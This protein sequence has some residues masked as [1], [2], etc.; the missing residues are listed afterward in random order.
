MLNRFAISLVFL[1]SSATFAAAESV[2][3]TILS[4]DPEQHTL[5]MESGE[6]W[7][8]SEYVVLEGLKPGQLVRVTYADETVDA[9]AVD[10]LEEAPVI[11]TPES[12][13]PE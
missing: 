3:G 9:T 6:I 13:T 11:E 5:T 7:N 2:D 12:V 1:A 8:L 4:L 10:V